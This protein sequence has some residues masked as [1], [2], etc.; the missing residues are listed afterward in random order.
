LLLEENATNDWWAMVRPA[1]RVRPGGHIRL[2]D[3][4]GA[5]SPVE[6]ELGDRNPAGHFRVRFYGSPNIKE[7]LERLGEVPLPPYIQRPGG[8]TAS[9]RE[10][11]QTVYADPAGSVA[12]PTAGLHFTRDLL[13]AVKE[14]GIQICH[15]TLH[16]GPGTFAPVKAGNLADHRM[17]EERFELEDE[18]AEK[19]EATKRSG[20]RIVAVG[21]TTVRVLESAAMNEAGALKGAVGRT[22]IFIYPPFD[23][24]VVD[25]L[26]TNFH[27]PQSTLLMLVSA[28]ASPGKTEGRELILSAYQEAVRDRYRFFSYGDAM[29]IL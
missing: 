9:D 29:L 2:L 22:S 21:T 20:G 25:A 4:S 12:A 10:R 27:L 15:V 16:V 11:Y 7:D 5:R 28:F 17:H 8:S 6:V 14:K 18:T 1:K 3:R 23:F 26:I 13:E 24:K 19:I